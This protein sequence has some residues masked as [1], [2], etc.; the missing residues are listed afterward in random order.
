MPPVL[1]FFLHVAKA[2]K[3]A[4]HRRQDSSSWVLFPSRSSS[5][6]PGW[7]MADLGPSQ[8]NL[9]TIATS[10]KSSG[11]NANSQI[12]AD[13]SHPHVDQPQ[14]RIESL[15]FMLCE[16]RLAH[17]TLVSR[18]VG[19]LNQAFT[20]TFV[21]LCH[22]R[23]VSDVM[24]LRHPQ[25]VPATC[26]WEERGSGESGRISLE[27]VNAAGEGGHQTRKL[28]APT[29]PSNFKQSMHPRAQDTVHWYWKYY[30]CCE[31]PVP[32]KNV[33]SKATRNI[34]KCNGGSGVK[35]T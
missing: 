16:N 34:A 27:A 11:S 13:E 1:S 8:R 22:S 29:N 32:R 6:W 14:V 25:T 7:K 12:S 19:S 31:S 24:H 4:A 28:Q 35:W 15:T 18:S 5:S 3:V 2:A 21:M 23:L 17:T 30:R 33:R 20:V 9:Q 26:S 10:W